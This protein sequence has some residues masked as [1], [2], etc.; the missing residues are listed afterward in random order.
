MMKSMNFEEVR[1]LKTYLRFRDGVILIGLICLFIILTVAG[2][3]ATKGYKEKYTALLYDSMGLFAENQKIQFEQFIENKVTVLQGL[4]AYAEIYEMN[5]E[6]QQSFLEGKAEQFGFREFFVVDKDGIGHYFEEDRQVNQSEEPFFR[7]IMS[8]AVYITEPFY[9]ADRIITTISVSIYDNGEKQGVLCGSVELDSLAQLFTES[10]MLMNGELILLNRD[11][12][13]LIADKET[14]VSNRRSI[15]EESDTEVA[16]IQK[17]FQQKRDKIGNLKLDGTK[18]TAYAAYLPEYDWV[19]VQC[20]RNSEIF[21][22]LSYFTLWRIGS[23]LI[24]ALISFCVLRLILG[25]YQ[26]IKRINT[27]VLTK[28]NSRSAMEH[29]LERLEENYYKEISI[30]YFDLNKFKQVNDVYGHEEG[31]RVLCVFA[32]VLMSVFHKYAKVG[33]MGGDEFLAVGIDVGKEK[34]EEL[35]KKVNASLQEKRKELGLP[36][37]V[38]TSFGYAV[39]EKRAQSPLA[40]IMKQ[41]DEA[42]YEYKKEVHKKGNVV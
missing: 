41:A 5:P 12:H 9:G 19:M 13:Y 7:N 14:K 26:S 35:C 31:D 4:S 23:M 18:Y 10:E 25:W 3:L 37:E 27:D 17:A 40:D 38:S 11:G 15:Y 16:L 39:R 8:E 1:Q 42:M 29:L 24:I 21:A 34:L 2:A 32:S 20:V 36:Y 6:K 33:R 22:A 28:C 30:I